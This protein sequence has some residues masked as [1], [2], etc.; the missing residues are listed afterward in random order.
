MLPNDKRYD[1][2]QIRLL[3][4]TVDELTTQGL[5]DIARVNE[6]PY[7]S[8]A[9]EGPEAIFVE[10]DLTRILTTIEHLAKSASAFRWPRTPGP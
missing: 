7:G 3:T 5:I 9:P 6:P 2:N 1:K 8:V 4:P 10:A